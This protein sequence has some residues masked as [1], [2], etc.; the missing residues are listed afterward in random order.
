MSSSLR[1]QRV[2]AAGVPIARLVVAATAAYVIATRLV[3]TPA[4]VLA[5]LTA[6]LVVSST[7]SATLRNGVQRIVS[8]IAGVLVALAVSTVV[9]L[10]WWS[11]GLV[12]LGALLVGRHLRLGDQLLE[13]PISA[14]L[15]LAVSWQADTAAWSR[16]DETLLGAIV[17]VLVSLSAPSLHVQPAGDALG[18]LG[19][20]TAALLRDVGGR[21]TREWATDDADGWVSDARGL[22][23]SV[24]EARGAVE[25]GEESL[26]LNPRRRSV[27]GAERSLASGLTSLESIAIHVRVICRSLRDRAAAA[28]APTVP[29]RW[30]LGHLLRASADAIDEF[31]ALVA[32][33]VTA[34]APDATRLRD[35][36]TRARTHAT[37][38]AEL[39][40]VDG[41][42]ERETWHAHGALLA[43]CDRLL[44]ELDP[45][46][47]GAEALGRPR[48]APR[49]LR[50][51]AASKSKPRLRTP[52]RLG[53]RTG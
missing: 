24:E 49:R 23:R 47:G 27:D 48:P 22:S 5:P 13:V 42:A 6:L 8:V 16:V 19:A 12:V 39:L 32:A 15:I 51:V 4:P 53:A 10:T 43:H 25:R 44:D 37:V 34:P 40:L 33:D 46:L 2:V 9:P 28:D 50:L 36:V 41:A 7:V 31:A 14:M 3:S 18:A 29:V 1:L 20:R 11:L 45:D 21:V 26:K 35:A 38:A 17:G 52:V 30:A